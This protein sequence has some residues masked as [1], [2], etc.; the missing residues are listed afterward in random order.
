IRIICNERNALSL[1]SLPSRYSFLDRLRLSWFVPS[2]ELSRS[3]R[4]VRNGEPVPPIRL[5]DGGNR[6]RP[7]DLPQAYQSRT[8]PLLCELGSRPRVGTSP[9]RSLLQ[10]NPALLFRFLSR[11]STIL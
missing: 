3:A 2:A 6:S 11:C 1:P 8:W 7:M 5:V 4:I 9:R 10:P